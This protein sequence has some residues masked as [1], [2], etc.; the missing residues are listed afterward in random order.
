MPYLIFLHTVLVL[1]REILAMLFLYYK[2]SDLAYHIKQSNKIW[3]QNVWIN[4][5]QFCPLRN[6]G[7]AAAVWERYCFVESSS[8]IWRERLP[9]LFQKSRQRE[10][11]L[12]T[13]VCR[14]SEFERGWDCSKHC[15][16]WLGCGSS[17]GPVQSPHNLLLSLST[18]NAHRVTSEHWWWS[19]WWHKS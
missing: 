7:R 4:N 13:L 19:G 5:R 10:R 14:N 15:Q 8:F 11:L 2:G 3:E 6:E 18:C 16:S 12:K 17:W 9:G 1:W